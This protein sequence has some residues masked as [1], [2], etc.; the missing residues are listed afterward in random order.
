MKC[1]KA[2]VITIPACEPFTGFRTD[3]PD[4]ALKL[5]VAY[6]GLTI[7][8]EGSTDSTGVFPIT[9]GLFPSGMVNEYDRFTL[10]FTDP[11]G[12][13]VDIDGNGNSTF[14]I[15]PIAEY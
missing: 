15:Q 7:P 10:T 1:H 6:A 13:F 2:P 11:E 9:L 5:T 4:T 3:L 14:I 8:T 12:Q